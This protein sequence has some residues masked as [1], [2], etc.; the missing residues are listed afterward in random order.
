LVYKRGLANASARYS[1]PNIPSNAANL[2][3]V[4]PSGQLTLSYRLLPFS[5][6]SLVGALPQNRAADVSKSQVSYSFAWDPADCTA[7]AQ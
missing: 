5:G 2:T 3:G 6:R 1:S 4:G 7:W